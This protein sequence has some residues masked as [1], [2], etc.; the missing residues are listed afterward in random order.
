M[1]ITSKNLD[2]IFRST[3]IRRTEIIHKFVLAILS[4]AKPT[5]KKSLKLIRKHPSN[6]FE[7]FLPELF[8]YLMLN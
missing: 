4:K 7:E 1:K 8:C 2:V 3:Q 6:N 5:Y